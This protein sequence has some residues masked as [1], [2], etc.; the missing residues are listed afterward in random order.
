MQNNTRHHVGYNMVVNVVDGGFFGLGLG[1]ASTVTVVPLFVATLTDSALI[2]GLISALH[3]IGWQLPQILT[4]NR[5]A[6]LR[7]Y[8]PMMMWLTI[9]ERAPYFGLALV[10]LLAP[11]LGRELTLALAF[12]LF[13]WQA[14]GGGFT[15]TAWQSMVAK[16]FPTRLHGTFYGLQS[17]AANLASGIGAVIAGF[18]LQ[19]AGVQY[20]F[21]L[22]F[23]VCAI[24]VFISFGLLGMTREAESPV[25]AVVTRTP[26]EFIAGLRAILARDEAFRWFILAR[27]AGQTAIAAFA[28]YTIYA[29]R[30]F[31]MPPAVGGILAGVLLISQM[32][33][34]TLLGWAGDRW[35]YRNMFAIGGVAAAASAFLAWTATSLETFYVVFALAGVASAGM[36]TVALAML[37]SFGTTGERP[38][39]IGLCNSLIAPAT[40]FAPILGG[41][42]ADN[43]GFGATF[44]LSI[45]A[46]VAACSVMLLAIRSAPASVP[47][48]L[49]AASGGD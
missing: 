35:G 47:S 15:A 1:F 45:G 49:A 30:R 48:M 42:L 26:R 23:F 34:S 4:A 27:I 22:C 14:L 36:W 29:T 25:E 2:I 12:I 19:G 18:I 24:A 17:A 3:L 37:A 10:A 20:G 43:F 31:D 38:Y 33:G 11:Q 44:A 13:A 8:K 40:L 32:V 46:A 41:W 6:S 16:I 28:F 21:A 39:Y 9:Q 5:V 7:R